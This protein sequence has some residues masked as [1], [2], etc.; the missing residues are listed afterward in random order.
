MIVLEEIHKTYPN[1]FCAIKGV[2][3]KIA[4]GDIFGIIGYSGA[5]KSTLVRIINRLEEPSSGRVV[6]EGENIL[7]LSNQEL[8]KRRQKI[9]MIFQHFN[10]MSSKNAFDNI[11]YA[12]KIAKWEKSRIKERVFELLELVGLKDKAYFYPSQ[13]SGGQKQRVAIARALANHPSILLCDEATSALDT[14]STTAILEL[15]KT[16]QK[17]LKITIVMITHQIEVVKNIC[18]KICVMDGGRIVEEGLTKEVFL[19]PKSEV[20]RELIA[21]LPEYD[22]REILPHIQDSAHTYEL[23]FLDQNQNTPVISQAIKKFGVDINILFADFNRISDKSLGRM[24]VEIKGDR[25][26]LEWIRAQ[27]IEVR[28]FVDSLPNKGEKDV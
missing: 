23:I 2:S 8:Q 11:A 6:I 17:H 5:G 28:N 19:H 16:I 4:R 13:L 15:L 12:L 25:Q 1:G 26:V 21:H 14:Q 9:G 3:F 18:N 24:I 20:T 10:L 7:E 27:N 22:C